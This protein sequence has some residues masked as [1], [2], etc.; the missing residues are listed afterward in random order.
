MLTHNKVTGNQR[1]Q[2][3]VNFFDLLSRNV[4]RVNQVLLLFDQKPFG[5]VTRKRAEALSHDELKVCFHQVVD[6]PRLRIRRVIENFA[7]AKEAGA[8]IVANLANLT[9]LAE[10]QTIAPHVFR[11]ARTANRHR[12]MLTVHQERQKLQGRR[13]GITAFFLVIQ[14]LAGIIAAIDAQVLRVVLAQALA[15]AQVDVFNRLDARLLPFGFDLDRFLFHRAEERQDFIDHR[16]INDREI[17]VVNHQ[18]VAGEAFAVML[19]ELMAERVIKFA[20]RE[21]IHPTPHDVRPDRYVSRGDTTEEV[22]QVTS[23]G[24][25]FL[26]RRAGVRPAADLPDRHVLG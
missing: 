13:E 19:I 18:V 6:L 10:E 11:E 25:N 16:A 20:I 21:F 2:R 23:P 1:V 14:N 4:R 24:C 8:R 22:I 26:D 9:P 7:L 17:Q 5:R 12:V 15:N 3:F